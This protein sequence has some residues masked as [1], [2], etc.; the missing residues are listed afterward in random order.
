MRLVLFL[1][2]VPIQSI[3]G[4]TP[5][6]ES[7][8]AINPP[9]SRIRAEEVERI[10]ALA[11]LSLRSEEVTRMRV[12][13]DAILDYVEELAALDTSQ[14]EVTTHVVPVST[15]LR[16]D[17]ARPSFPPELA[18]SNAPVPEGDAFVVPKVIEGEEG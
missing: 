7:V 12:H 5:P 13:L 10:A 6:Q 4:L 16:E 8:R 11:R 18:L 15:A 3:F 14:V 9:M 1:S 17:V 2:L